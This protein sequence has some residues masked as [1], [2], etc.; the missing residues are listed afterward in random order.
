[1]RFAVVGLGHIAQKAVLPAFASCRRA[2]LAAVVSGDPRKAAALGRRFG[3]GAW[4]GYAPREFERGLAEASVEAVYLAVPTAAHRELT[5]RSARAGVHVLCEKPLAPTAADAEAMLRASRR[6]NVR[7]MVAYRLHFDPANR[8]AEHLVADGRLGRPL[9]FDSVFTIQVR[10]GDSRLAPAA[11]GGGPLHDIGIYCINA[12][13][14]LLGGEPVEVLG[15]AY[16]GSGPGIPIRTFAGT[17]RF[18][19]GAVATFSCGFGPVAVS[20]YE[21]VGTAGRLVMDPAYN[22]RGELVQTVTVDGRSR[23][24]SFPHRDQFAAELDA[25]ADAVR[26]GRP[27][28]P[29]GEEGLADL[30]VVDALYRSVARRRLISL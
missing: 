25:M 4:F 2:R 21:L 17:L 16:E 6:H 7:L 15:T 3:A 30:R 9:V 11:R 14:R 24:R 23:T 29:S 22:Y 1:M 26:S 18:S 10:R 8:R 20:R 19:N 28:E 5:E 27:P 13:R 12:A